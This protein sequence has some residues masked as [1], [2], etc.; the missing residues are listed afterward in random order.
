M[1]RF[2]GPPFLLYAKGH[3]HHV[4][5]YS[6]QAQKRCSP[7]IK[8]MRRPAITLELTLSRIKRQCMHQRMLPSEPPFGNVASNRSASASKRQTSNLRRRITELAER[9]LRQHCPITIGSQSSIGMRSNPLG[10]QQS[11]GD[12]YCGLSVREGK[13]VPP[14]LF[15]RKRHNLS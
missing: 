7:S 13:S 9:Q 10:W 15:L 14:H 6:D 11:I 4:H 12:I 1:R 2:G 3:F 5:V 8:Q